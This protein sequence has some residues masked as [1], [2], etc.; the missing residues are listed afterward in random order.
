MKEWHQ[1]GVASLSVACGLVL[2]IGITPSYMTSIH[3]RYMAI[4]GAAIGAMI[5]IAY[6]IKGGPLLLC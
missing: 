1:T 4:S 2:A 6:N 3:K 5:G